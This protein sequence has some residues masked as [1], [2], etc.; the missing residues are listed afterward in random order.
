[1]LA[2]LTGNYRLG[3]GLHYTLGGKAMKEGREKDQRK[4]QMAKAIDGDH[5]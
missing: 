3:Q 4:K 1:M 5:K 2:C